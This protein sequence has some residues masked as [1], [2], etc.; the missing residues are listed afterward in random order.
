MMIV[1]YGNKQ[2]RIN[3]IKT[4][5]SYTYGFSFNYFYCTTVIFPLNLAKKRVTQLKVNYF[6]V[7]KSV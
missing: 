5:C 2:C 4:Y 6:R 7:Q 1:S 3:H